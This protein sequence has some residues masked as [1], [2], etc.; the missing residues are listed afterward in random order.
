MALLLTLIRQWFS[1][2]AALRAENL[3]LR[4]Q[5]A[6]F[7]DRKQQQRPRKITP[8]I[9]L[10]M[11]GLAR[12]FEWRTAL[13]IVKPETFLKWHRSAFRALW[14]RN[15]KLGRPALPN[16]IRELIQ[17]MARKQSNLG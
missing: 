10:V 7:A 14:R 9:R 11:I 6:L 1:L 4:K 2:R 13:V 3:F 15:S 16:N 8:L 12:F 5:L 17:C